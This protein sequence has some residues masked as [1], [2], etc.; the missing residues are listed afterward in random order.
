MRLPRSIGWHLQLWYGALLALILA[1]FGGTAWRLERATQLQRVDQDLERRVAAV[2]GALGPEG[3][4]PRRPPADRPPEGPRADAPPPPPPPREDRPPERAERRFGGEGGGAFYYVAWSP[5]GRELGRSESAPRDVPLP[6]RGDEPRGFRSRGPAR[7]YF[8]FTPGGPCVLVGRDVGEEL[9]A[10]RRFAGLLAAA[11]GAVFALGLAGGRWISRRAL[12]PIAE[13]SATAARIST[14]DLAQRIPVAG[15]GNELDELARVLNGTFAR[16]QASFARLEA[17]STR[18]AQFTADASHELRTPVSVVLTRT[19]AALARERT[20]AEYRESLVVCR[21]AAQRMRSLIE[22]LLTLA[23]LD[24]GRAVPPGSACG[25]DR[26]AGDVV[27]LLRPEAE[28]GGVGLVA[29][30]EPVRCAGHAE[31]LGQ[32]VAN[33]VGNAIH[34]NHDGG[35]VRIR[36]WAEGGGACLSVS[37]TGCGI[38]PED[39]PH[40]FERFYRADRSR[41]GAAGRA[42]LG[43][44]IVKAI[45]EAHGGSVAATSDPGK[46]SVFTVRLARAET[47]TPSSGGRP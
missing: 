6:R 11:G 34:Y 36:T 25:L 15:D 22:S 20:A 3:A 24:S 17:S 27:E 41:S 21:E 43:L 9:A 42:G 37:D 46:G 47:A 35:E 14:G 32:V 40:V 8:H 28:R 38:A 4:V 31:L 2:V 44:A 18:Q 39:L 19:Q 29:D 26:V 30:L 13:I 33:L 7:E 16:L 45:V 10:I 23:R 1:G 12:R 5:D